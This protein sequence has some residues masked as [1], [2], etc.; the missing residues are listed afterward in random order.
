MFIL[1]FQINYILVNCK[2]I[3]LDP[4]KRP[5]CKEILNMP[6]I[7]QK[8]KEIKNLEDEEKK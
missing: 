3:S 5:S 6:I 7:Q 8:I 2:I 4:K 1:Q